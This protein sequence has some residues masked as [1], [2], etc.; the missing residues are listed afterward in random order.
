MSKEPQDQMQKLLNL[1]ERM[2]TPIVRFCLKRGIA[3]SD[4]V[5]V[6]KRAY[7]R[8]AEV[9]LRAH[10]PNPSASRIAAIT[11]VH[12]KDIVRFAKSPIPRPPEQ[13]II[14]RVM[15]QWKHDRRFSKR[16]GIAKKLT[17]EGHASE[18][19]QLVGAVTGRDI[20]FYSILH[21][22]ERLNIIKRD[23]GLVELLWQ[24]FVPH[25]KLDEAIEMYAQDSDALLTAIEENVSEKDTTPNL[26]LR[27]VFDNIVL[28]A[29]PEI[30]QWILKEGSLFQKRVAEYL[31]QFDKDL[32]PELQ[33]KPG[34]G[35]ILCA[36]F[37]RIEES[38]LDLNEPT[39]RALPKAPLKAKSD[40][41][42]NKTVKKKPK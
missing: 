40:R 17:T 8:S 29:L 23:H 42:R 3:L 16:G 37:S 38:A 2:L 10:D 1:L 22:M 27:T 32:E 7:V 30:K 19:A 25:P 39:N 15:T 34:G 4:F 26:H 35:K 12:R 6:L 18:F 33:N 14:G 24:D 21:E 9:E 20:S 28:D 13:N 11:G 5:E 41:L 31:A 36:S